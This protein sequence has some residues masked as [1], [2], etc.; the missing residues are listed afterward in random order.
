MPGT[1]YYQLINK[2]GSEL[3]LVA[4]VQNPNNWIPAAPATIA[5]GGNPSLNPVEPQNPGSIVFGYEIK[6]SSTEQFWVIANAEVVT[7][8]ASPGH[9]IGVSVT[10]NSEDGWSVVLTYQ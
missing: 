9:S 7:Q 4:T 2:T 3:D 1:V 6:G 8:F 5:A 10:G